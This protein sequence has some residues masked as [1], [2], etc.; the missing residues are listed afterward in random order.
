MNESEKNPKPELDDF[1]KEMLRHAIESGMD[2]K[3]FFRLLE[4]TKKNK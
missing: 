1:G 3:E 2:E 4:E